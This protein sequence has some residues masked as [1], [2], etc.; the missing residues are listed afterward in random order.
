MKLI[1]KIKNALFEEDEEETLKV[2][3]KE[4]VKEVPIAKKIDIEKTVESSEKGEEVFTSRKEE[5]LH[6][7][8]PMSFIC[9]FA[10]NTVQISS[11]DCTRESENTMDS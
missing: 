4:Q 9:Y 8:L 5:K 6:G 3:K 10:M 7:Y 2:P 1:E 11:T